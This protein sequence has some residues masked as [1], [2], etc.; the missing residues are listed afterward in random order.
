M[1]QLLISE[2][3]MHGYLKQLLIL[4]QH[5]YWAIQWSHRSC[6]YTCIKKFSY[7]LG[8]WLCVVTVL[9]PFLIFFYVLEK[10]IAFIGSTML[11]QIKFL[12]HLGKGWKLD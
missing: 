11:L 12:A 7:Y 5:V 8:V 3:N 1:K 6:M 10:K 9:V 2:S 4:V